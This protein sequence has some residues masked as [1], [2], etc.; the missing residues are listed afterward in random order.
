MTS[1]RC[2]ADVSLSG[3]SPQNQLETWDTPEVC[4]LPEGECPVYDSGCNAWCAEAHGCDSV[5]SDTQ[6]TLD[7]RIDVFQYGSPI[8]ELTC[9]GHALFNSSFGLFTQCLAQELDSESCNFSD[10][11]YQACGALLEAEC[12]NGS[13]MTGVE[14]CDDNNTTTETCAYGE[15]ECTVCNASC[16][17]VAGETSYCG[18][19][20][21]QQGVEQ[22]DD[23]NSVDGDGCS[24]ECVE[25][26]TV[27][28]KLR[29]RL[30]AEAT[31]DDD[32][33]ELRVYVTDLRDEPTGVQG[34]EFALFAGIGGYI[35][36]AP[37]E[38]GEL[39]W[40]APYDGSPV[41]VAD[42]PKDFSEAQG[43]HLSFPL[44]GVSAGDDPVGPGEFLVMTMVFKWDGDSGS[45]SSQASSLSL[46]HS[47]ALDGEVLPVSPELIEFGSVDLFP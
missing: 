30:E 11:D 40:H 47:M 35:K 10:L 7:S 29:L 16:Q 23:G 21:V 28:Y 32:W 8:C 6:G 3:A 18:D 26:E 45:I 36:E 17:L 5:S 34:L 39:V 25:E 12:G 9:A 13:V 44:A 24:V 20:D 2:R 41:L 33:F 42:L 37:P 38:K 15:T 31:D 46:T 19:G 1:W 43:G 14:E 22:C 27:D 4:Q